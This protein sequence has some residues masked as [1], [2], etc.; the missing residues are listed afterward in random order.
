MALEGETVAIGS[1]STNKGI[2]K[3]TVSNKSN[4]SGHGSPLSRSGSYL[5]ILE[6]SHD[7]NESLGF[8]C[9]FETDMAALCRKLTFLAPN[10]CHMTRYFKVKDP[11]K[12]CTT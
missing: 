2:L 12:K 11:F 1:H 7:Q 3:D 9:S 8:H 6:K 4:L 5:G 10:Q